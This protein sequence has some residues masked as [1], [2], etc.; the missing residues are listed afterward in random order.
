MLQNLQYLTGMTAPM[1]RPRFLPG[2]L[3][4]TA[5][6]FGKTKSVLKLSQSRFIV[7]DRRFFTGLFSRKFDFIFSHLSGG[8]ITTNQKLS[9]FYG[10]I[11]D[12][13]FFWILVTVTVSEAMVI[14]SS[15][16]MAERISSFSLERSIR[17]LRASATYRASRV[18]QLSVRVI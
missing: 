17:R 1:N 16:S 9:I 15:F 10:F 14:L 8:N 11:G 18:I 13:A 6:I 3:F 12:P 7:M 4:R 5:I 2:I